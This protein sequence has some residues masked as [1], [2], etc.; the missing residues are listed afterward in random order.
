M[1]TPRYVPS[2]PRAWLGVR[3]SGAG[4]ARKADTQ[5]ALVQQLGQLLADPAARYRVYAGFSGWAP[6]QLESEFMRDGWYVLPAELAKELE[7]WL[8]NPKMRK[9]LT[10]E[11]LAM[12]EHL[13]PE[14][15]RRVTG[16]VFGSVR[17]AADRHGG[18]I[19]TV[20]R[21]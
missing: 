5:E 14:A 21:K 11:E 18:T 16:L 9:D 12:L 7:E 15:L 17:D 2:T 10:P 20:A 19:E 6:R 13:D 1:S 3:S 4:G 8:R